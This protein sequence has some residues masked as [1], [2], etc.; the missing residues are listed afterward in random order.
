[1]KLVAKVVVVFLVLTMLRCLW[2]VCKRLRHLVAGGLDRKPKEDLLSI[3]IAIV[4]GIILF[5][6]AFGI[7]WV[8]GWE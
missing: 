2:V 3:G 7:V 4:I 6:L 8:V 5:G 1:M